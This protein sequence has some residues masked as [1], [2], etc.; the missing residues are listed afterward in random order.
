MALCFQRV[1][2]E[3]LGC[4]H[5]IPHMKCQLEY[6]ELFVSCFMCP[7]GVYVTVVYCN[8][9]CRNIALVKCV[10]FSVLRVS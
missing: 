5:L 4:M 9:I 2:Y 1:S 3:R 7:A 8:G 6:W 10:L